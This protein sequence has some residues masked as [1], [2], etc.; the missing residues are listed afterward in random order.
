MNK[1]VDKDMCY[2]SLSFILGIF[3]ELEGTTLSLIA[4]LNISQSNLRMILKSFLEEI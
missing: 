1:L 3:E 2:L 4:N